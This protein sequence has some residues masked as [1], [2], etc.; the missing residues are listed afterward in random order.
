MGKID[1]EQEPKLEVVKEE[2][3]QEQAAPEEIKKGPSREEI[4]QYKEDFQNAYKTFAEKKWTIS[5]PGNFP[6]NDVGFY[7]L[8][9]MKK[10]AFWSKTEWMGVL[11]MEEEI[12][13]SMPLANETT[14]LQLGYQAL[15]FC[16]YMMANPGGTGIELAKEFEKQADKYSKI[17]IVVG[18]R[19]EE[20]RKELKEIQ[21][22][23]EK[24]AAGEQGFFYEREPAPEPEVSKQEISEGDTGT[25][26][27]KEPTE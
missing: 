21:F 20:A 10:Y 17:G 26:P 3:L 2:I 19:I 25:P 15:E 23:Q 18:T 11:K 12:N 16:A 5:D 8:D 24:W 13:A 27:T 7:L 4:D 6:A 14:G 22:L 1:E 9:F